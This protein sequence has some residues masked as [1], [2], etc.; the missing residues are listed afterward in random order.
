MFKILKIKNDQKGVVLVT[1]I[2]ITLV[3]MILAVGL[4]GLNV[5][6][7]T[8]GEREVERIQAKHLAMGAWWDA[9]TNLYSGGD[10][11]A[12]PPQTQV[13]DGK[14]FTI[15]TQKVVDNPDPTPD[16]YQ[17]DVTYTQD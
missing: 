17:I 4:L 14:T 7:V 8:Q 16:E 13:L 12:G 15:Q 5:S 9:Y 6:Q 11:T 1:V 10:P 3:M 2:V